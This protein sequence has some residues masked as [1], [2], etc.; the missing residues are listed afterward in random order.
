VQFIV[1]AQLPPM[2]ARALTAAGHRSEAVRDLGL[3]EA[4]DES[5]WKYASDHQRAIVTKDEDFANRVWQTSHGPAVVWLR[6]GNCS[7]RELL[8]RLI[9]LLNAIAERIE[10]GDRLVE[11]S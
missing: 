6:I 8:A 5:I 9:P 3:R 1:D 4:D 7:N 10:F 11:I 2:L